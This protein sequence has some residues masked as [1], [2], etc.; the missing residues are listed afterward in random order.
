[1]RSESAGDLSRKVCREGVRIRQVDY[2]RSREM[3]VAV[4]AGTSGNF[5]QLPARAANA[6]ARRALADSSFTAN[7]SAVLTSF[8]VLELRRNAFGSFKAWELPDLKTFAVAVVMRISDAYGLD[9]VT[10]RAETRKA[11][12]HGV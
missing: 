7:P 3:F 9:L 2:S 4:F 6:F 5:G 11:K 12:V 1:M 8:T 10:A